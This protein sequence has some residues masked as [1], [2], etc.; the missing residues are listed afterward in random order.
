MER[1]R[2]EVE[3]K[4]DVPSEK[5]KKVP[6]GYPRKTKLQGRLPKGCTLEGNG[7]VQIT[8][9]GTHCCPNASNSSGTTA[10]PWPVV[11]ARSAQA[12]P[13]EN[14]LCTKWSFSP[15]SFLLPLF[16]SSFPP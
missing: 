5:R 1:G 9:L 12:Q 6:K 10:N 3:K 14:V 11:P 15:V 8:E 13:A 2:G 4:W 7:P 16:T